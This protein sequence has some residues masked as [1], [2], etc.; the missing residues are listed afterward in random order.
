M[1]GIELS[2]TKVTKTSQLHHLPKTKK[3]RSWKLRN[4]LGWDK[5][6]EWSNKSSKDFCE[7]VTCTEIDHRS[8]KNKNIK[9]NA[10]SLE[11]PHKTI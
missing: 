10:L 2:Q 5:I 11:E 7:E 1:E 9:S 4:S 3:Q 8:L 6:E